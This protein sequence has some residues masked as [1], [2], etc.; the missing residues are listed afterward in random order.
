MHPFHI[1]EVANT[2]GGEIDY[3]L[4]LISEF[5]EFR[6]YGMKFQPLH[7]DKIATS[8]FPW[9]DVYK[10]LYFSNSQWR[11]IIES[12]ARTKEIWLD[13]FDEYGVEVLHENKS[14]IKGVKLQSSI[15]FN[16]VVIGKLSVDNGLD[17]HLLIINISGYAP[18]AVSERIGYLQQ[19]LKPKELLLEVGF[20]AFPTELQDSG[21]VKIDQVRKAFGRRVVF[22]DHADA[23]GDDSVWLPILAAMNGADGIEKHIKHSSRETKYDHYSSLTKEKYKFF[24]DRLNAYISLN[25]QPFINQREKEYLEK[26][27]QVPI[28]AKDLKKGMLVDFTR[29]LE[30]KRSGQSGLNALDI[31]KLQKDFHILSVDAKKGCVLS[32]TNFKRATIGVVIAC[33]LK[34]SRLPRKALL[35]IGELSSVEKCIESCRRISNVNHTILATSVLQE[36]AELGSYTFDPSVIF[37]Q[38]DPDDVIRRYLAIAEQLKIDVIVRVTADCPFV[39]DE[40]AQIL[41]NSHFERGAD[42]SAAKDV[43]VGTGVEIINV[44]A[45][46]KI[47][48]YF[49]SANY[50]EYMTWYFQNNPEHFK[51][52]IVKLPDELVR[53][54]RLTLD[55]P[56]DLEL[57]NKIQEHLISSK[58]DPSLRNIFEYLDNNPEV[59][60]I[61]SHL[62]LKYKTDATL[63]E[64]LNAETKI[65]DL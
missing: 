18:D 1:L 32:R 46:R 27:L 26:T 47:K 44:A 37:H 7:P 31:S 48:D 6:G 21:F 19:R 60:I 53:N 9:Y 58:K 23:Q 38:G 30:F 33:R 40:I 55:Y 64:T 12:A 39:S 3:V 29:D 62:T 25:Q 63:I 14:T 5:E 59:A 49:P 34:S 56:E 50:S 43:A 36:D 20:Q 52:N 51:L 16:E 4:D 42:Y 28:L 17:Q 54:Y 10:Q 45:M 57:L 15:L 41:L 11:T 65:R 13:I 61:N 35:N 8:D 24:I 2:H 22:A